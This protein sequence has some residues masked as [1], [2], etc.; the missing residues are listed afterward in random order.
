MSLSPTMAVFFKF[1][2]CSAFYD[3]D[4]GIKFM[5]LR[6]RIWRFFSEFG[7]IGFPAFSVNQESM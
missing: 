4:C 3:G 2:E 7:F 1:N 6:P 5:G